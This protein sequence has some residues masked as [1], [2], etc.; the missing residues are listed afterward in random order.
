[1]S[2][3]IDWLVFESDSERVPSLSD[4]RVLVSVATEVFIDKG[5]KVNSHFVLLIYQSVQEND[6][7]LR[8][9]GVLIV[10]VVCWVIFTTKSN[11]II[12]EFFEF[13]CI[14]CFKADLVFRRVSTRSLDPFL[15]VD[16][17]YDILSKGG[18]VLGIH[19]F[20]PSD[21]EVEESE[22]L[23]RVFLDVG[24]HKI[25]EVSFSNKTFKVSQELETLLVRELRER[26]V[27]S[28]TIEDWI[29]RGVS[30]VDSV[31]HNVNP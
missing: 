30:A 22:T 5:E 17:Q 14:F 10:F 28:V 20:F 24:S 25:L 8:I 18:V 12:S 6:F 26:V 4:F 23:E 29:E 3:I 21:F 31:I 27:W 19:V 13:L 15:P 16:S 1:M 7:K 2:G 9:I 11:V